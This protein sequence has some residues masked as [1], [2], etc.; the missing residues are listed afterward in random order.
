MKDRKRERKNVLTKYLLSTVCNSMV[1]KLDNR[2]IIVESKCGFMKV[3]DTLI[4]AKMN[5]EQG[6][7]IIKLTSL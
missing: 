6:A 7:T 3:Y 1:V 5:K 2:D 4:E